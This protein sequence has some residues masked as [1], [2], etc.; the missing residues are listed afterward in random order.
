MSDKIPIPN[1]IIVK[2]DSSEYELYRKWFIE[3]MKDNTAEIEKVLNGTIEQ[4]DII[5]L[6]IFQE[7]YNEHN[8]KETI[9][10]I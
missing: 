5:I 3:K 7:V 9:E 2:R 6:F 1:R 10:K 4:Y 8:Q